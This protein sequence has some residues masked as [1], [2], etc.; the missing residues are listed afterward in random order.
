MRREELY[1]T[2]ML[3]AADAIGRFLLETE[4]HSFIANELLGNSVLHKLAVIGEGSARLPEAFRA[5]HPQIEWGD[6]VAFRNII[7]H[8]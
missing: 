1:L 4:Q 3:E 8:V 5:R 2:D 7:V 6:I